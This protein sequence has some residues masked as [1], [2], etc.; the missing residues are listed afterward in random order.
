ME[1]DLAKV[2]HPLAAKPMLGHVLTTL[3]AIDN[4]KSVVVVGHQADAVREVCKSYGVESAL[5]AEQLG[6]GHA[7]LQ[8]RALLEGEEGYT[9]LLSGDVPLLSA[10]TL[11]DLLKQ[12]VEAGAAAA[13]L[14]AVT[15]DATGYGRI[16][17]DE[18]GHVRAIVEHKDATPAQREIQEYNTGTYCVRN[19][20]L[21]SAL[22]R[23]GSNNAQGE[24]Y[25]TDFVGILVGE[26]KTVLG[27]ICPDEREVQGVNTLA[28]LAKVELDYAA[29]RDA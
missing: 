9:L 6:T 25:L 14:S 18:A 5:Q 16:L 1:S 24:F 12:T 10:A 20:L 3:A 19:E 7:V 23:V 26:G 21:W 13:V 2:L 17:R 29:M 15:D 8:A 22:D 27:V 28:D 11:R 4:A